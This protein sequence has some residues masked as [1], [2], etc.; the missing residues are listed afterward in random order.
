MKTLRQ[1]QETT[2]AYKE[3]TRLSGVTPE[4]RAQQMD[5]VSDKIEQQRQDFERDMAAQQAKMAAIKNKHH[6][7][8]HMKEEVEELDEAYNLPD[9]DIDAQIAH[10]D[11]AQRKHLERYVDARVKRTTEKKH[12]TDPTRVQKVPMGT[13]F[14][15]KMD[16]HK[17]QSDEE[18]VHVDLYSRH[19]SMRDALKH[20]KKSGDK[21]QLTYYKNEH[22]RTQDRY[23][24]HPWAGKKINEEVEELDEAL[25]HEIAGQVARFIGNKIDPV[26]GDIMHAHGKEAYRQA[27]YHIRNTIHHISRA[28]SDLH[29]QLHQHLKTGNPIKLKLGEEVELD[30]GKYGAFRVGPRRPKY[31]HVPQ[32]DRDPRTGLPLG[33]SPP[34]NK[35]EP[36]KVKEATYQGKDV[37]LNKPMAGDVKKSKVYVDPDGDGKAQKV[38]FGDKTM[39]IKKDQPGRKKSFLARHNCDDKNDK[40]KAGYW[41][42]KAWK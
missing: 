40:T 10:H 11:K 41:S 42:C 22:K 3:F 7:Q 6:T 9:G 19:V 33:F 32:G 36:K 38:N 30:E 24:K 37:P 15:A 16:P 4:Q 13:V 31:P 2:R 12:P 28:V 25:R 5:D 21:K 26:H 35:D 17:N 14:P 27:A 39:S 23:A 20:Y 1:L 8:D 18:K 34:P 29:D